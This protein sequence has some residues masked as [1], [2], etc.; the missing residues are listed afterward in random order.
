MLHRLVRRFE[1]HAANTP[2]KIAN[3]IAMRKQRIWT[4]A[5]IVT[6]GVRIEGG[7]FVEA[8]VSRF[9]VSAM[10][11]HRPNRI[12]IRKKYHENTTK[13]RVLPVEWAAKSLL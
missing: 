5:G 3:N 10:R 8:A 12:E 9:P 6:F 1:V 13:K 2:N 7:V 4:I 11:V